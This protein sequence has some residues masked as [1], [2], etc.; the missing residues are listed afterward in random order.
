MDKT[1]VQQL[2]EVYSPS[3]GEQAVGA[4]LVEAMRARGFRAR[5]DEVG[6]AVGTLGTGPLKVYLVGHMDTVPGVIPVRVAEGKL[7]GRGS[8]DAKGCLAA[9]VEACAAFKDSKQLTL[10][11]IGCVEEE[12]SSRGA[13]H[14]LASCTP[15]DCVII[16]EPSGWDA[17]TLGYK[18]S[19]SLSYQLSKP[20]AHQ[21]SFSSTAAEDAVEFYHD[22][23]QAYP[24]RGPGFVAL[25]LNLVS[26][27]AET[28][29][30]HERATLG[31]NV[32][33]PPGFDLS[34]LQRAAERARGAARVQWGAFTPAVLCDKRN[35]LVRAFL[36]A[37]HASEGR[38]R[39]KR[40]TGTSDMNLLKRWE[41]PMLAYGP[42][43]SSLDH[44]PD[45]HLDLAE[46]RRAIVVL[47]HALAQLEDGP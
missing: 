33:T 36:G 18:G 41:C 26:I 13:Q 25:S 14:V 5:L 16:G 43:D 42:G 31:L 23:C 7:Y 32:R 1:L 28:Q 2:V 12:G 45:E 35:A 11:V 47:K 3:G 24:E 27:N 30:N 44:T 15:P 9:F 19:C 38:P 8:V 21:G 40:K 39:F 4:R 29:G 37:I 22:L 17:L 6:N 10:S 20:R 34:A 46:Y